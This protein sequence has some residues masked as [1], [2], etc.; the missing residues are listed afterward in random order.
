M[1]LPAN[2]GGKGLIPGSGRSPRVGNGSL[3]Q[4]TCLKNPRNR[5]AWWATD[6]GVAELDMTE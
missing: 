1:G 3:L 5:G 6:H 2:A 4:Y